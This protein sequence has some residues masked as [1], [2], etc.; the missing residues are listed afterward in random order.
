MPAVPLQQF[1]QELFVDGDFAGFQRSDF[2]LVVVHQD[3]LVAEVGKARARHQ[4]HIAR[5]YYGDVHA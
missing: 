1:G 3:H 2:G 5:T 4:S